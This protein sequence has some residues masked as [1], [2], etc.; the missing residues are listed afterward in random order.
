MPRLKVQ[1]PRREAAHTFSNR[2]S[3]YSR[4]SSSPLTVLRQLRISILEIQPA[5]QLVDVRAIGLHNVVGQRKG[6]VA[7]PVENAERREQTRAHQRSGLR[8][9]AG[10]YSRNSAGCSAPRPRGIRYEL[11]A[12]KLRPVDSRRLCS[13]AVVRVAALDVHVAGFQFVSVYAPASAAGR[14][15]CGFSLSTICF[16]RPF[17]SGS[18]R[19]DLRPVAARPAFGWS[20]DSSAWRSASGCSSQQDD[21]HVA[22]PTARSS[23]GSVTDVCW[24]SSTTTPMSSIGMLFRRSGASR[25]ADD[26]LAVCAGSGRRASRRTSARFS[27]AGR[28]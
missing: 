7:V 13:S 25:V 18:A 1:A 5:D 19:S 16:H 4:L 11:R 21:G 15:G 10:S 27:M 26:Q 6:V 8:P 2:V 24:S 14:P 23:S 12:E 20:P 28:L 9:R 22:D 17:F 3:A